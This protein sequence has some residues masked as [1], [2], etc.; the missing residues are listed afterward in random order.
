MSI[1]HNAWNFSDEQYNFFR[2]LFNVNESLPTREEYRMFF[3]EDLIVTPPRFRPV[4]K[5][6]GMTSAHP[7]TTYYE[8]IIAASNELFKIKHN[9]DIE[10]AEAKNEAKGAADAAKPKLISLIQDCIN[11]LFVSND[12]SLPNSIRFF[13]FFF[14]FRSPLFF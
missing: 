8:K 11:N 5:F 1:F 12:P 7:H 2:L 10:E 3:I 9:T 6:A 4:A 13:F 14:S